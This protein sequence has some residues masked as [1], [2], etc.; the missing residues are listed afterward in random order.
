[1]ALDS[2][3]TYEIPMNLLVV[4]TFLTGFP[5]PYHASLFGGN[6]F[7]SR[8]P[9]NQEC[10]VES[11]YLALRYH[12]V[13]TSYTSVK[14]M[15]PTIENGSRRMSDIVTCLEYFGLVVRGMRGSVQ[16]LKRHNGSIIMHLRDVDGN[17]EKRH[18][19]NHFVFGIYDRKRHAFVFADPQQSSALINV[20][21]KE[22]ERVW[23]GNAL[24]IH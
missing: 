14:S 17:G 1:M 11:A 4:I 7:Y 12:G 5:D 24:L 23:A 2:I 3:I 21:E 22:F 13:H 15:I 10:A 19:M 16:M 18:I 8:G 6:E 9:G 20:G